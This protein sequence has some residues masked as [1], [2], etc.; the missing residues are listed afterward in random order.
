MTPS[1][2]GIDCH[3]DVDY[4]HL[5]AC[6]NIDLSKI[7]AND[8]YSTN[9]NICYDQGSVILDDVSIGNWCQI[10]YN[11]ACSLVWGQD[12]STGISSRI[13]RFKGQDLL[14]FVSLAGKKCGSGSG[15]VIST[16]SQDPNS[17]AGGW[18]MSFCLVFRGQEA[19]CGTN[20][21]YPQV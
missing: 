2:H 6:Y 17:E 20:Q 18:S 7:N 3:T 11:G 5:S 8:I 9:D 14:D 1:G 19:A 15:A 4:T 10:G 12:L 13:S 16:T 21:G